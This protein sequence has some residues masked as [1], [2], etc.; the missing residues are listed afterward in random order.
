[1]L[2]GKLSFLWLISLLFPIFVSFASRENE[3][4]GREHYFTVANKKTAMCSLMNVVRENHSCFKLTHVA[5]GLL[6]SS[7]KGMRILFYLDFCEI[8]V[9]LCLLFFS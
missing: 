2:M 4:K 8:F 3:Q 9:F 6:L 5:N 1:K 7:V